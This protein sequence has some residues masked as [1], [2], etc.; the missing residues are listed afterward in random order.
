MYDQGLVRVLLIGVTGVGSTII[1]SWNIS[2]LLFGV[3]NEWTACSGPQDLIWVRC[4]WRIV[5]D[6]PSQAAES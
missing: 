5:K 1:K 4:T 2:V 6:M 3:L